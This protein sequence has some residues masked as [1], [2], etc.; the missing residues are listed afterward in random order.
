MNEALTVV[1]GED[2]KLYTSTD[3]KTIIFYGEERKKKSK[4]TVSPISQ[5]VSA[6]F[7]SVIELAF[8]SKVPNPYFQ[9]MSE[10]FKQRITYLSMLDYEG[11]L[12]Q[13]I[14]ENFNGLTELSVENTRWGKILTDLK[15]CKIL[16]K[17]WF[18]RNPVEKTVSTPF[19]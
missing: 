19:H 17:A 14:C 4:E 3:T 9:Q 1:I 18:R 6:H 7:P 8:N 15:K 16:K 5:S 12:K 2:A 10:Q 11:Q 13:S